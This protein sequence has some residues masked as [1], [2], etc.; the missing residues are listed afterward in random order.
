MLQRPILSRPPTG[1]LV[2]LIPR[3]I[4]RH[5]VVIFKH[6]H[7]AKSPRWDLSHAYRGGDSTRVY[8]IQWIQMADLSGSIPPE[9]LSAQ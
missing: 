5:L 3:F 4:A 1:N 8:W 9:Q 2:L 6:F 7:M